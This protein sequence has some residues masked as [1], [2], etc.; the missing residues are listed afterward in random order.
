MSHNMLIIRQFI[1]KVS[2]LGYF[3][4]CVCAHTNIHTNI[5]TH[6][7]INTYRYTIYYIIIPIH[8][9][10]YSNVKYVYNLIRGNTNNNIFSKLIRI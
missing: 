4:L 3:P 1:V 8:Y 2:V 9:P 5:H 7:Y 6:I 10:S